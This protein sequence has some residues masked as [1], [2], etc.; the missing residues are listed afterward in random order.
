M[1]AST[2]PPQGSFLATGRGKIT[3]ALL[4]AVTFLD[5]VDGLTVNVAAHHPD[6][7]GV[8]AEP[9]VGRQRLSDHPWRLPAAGRSGCG[10][11]WV[12]GGCWSPGPRCSRPPRWPAGWP[13]ARGCWSAAGFAQGFGA[14]MMTPGRAVHPDHRGFPG[15]RP[16]ARALGVWAGSAGWPRCVGV[17]FGGLLTQELGRRCALRKPPDSCAG[18]GRRAS[19]PKARPRPVFGAGRFRRPGARSWS[20]PELLMLSRW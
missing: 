3:L 10:T 15:L 7:S 16:A 17:F 9:A 19:I 18:A 8:R 13:T 1:T 6:A 12:G 20:P 14:A 2:V 11:R 5:V 4:C